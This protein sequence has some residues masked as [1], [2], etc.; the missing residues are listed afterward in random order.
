MKVG[1]KEESQMLLVYMILQQDKL[2]SIL[3]YVFEAAEKEVQLLRLREKRGR[4]RMLIE[5][6]VLE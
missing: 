3:D 5:L 1:Y 2:S 6:G 4:M